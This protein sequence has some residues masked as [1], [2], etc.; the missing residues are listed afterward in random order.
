M[1][2][3][4]HDLRTNLAGGEG[5]GF[6]FRVDPRV[7]IF[8][9]L[10]LLLIN[11]S[12]RGPLLPVILLLS[13]GVLLCFSGIDLH[14]L[15]KS[16]TIPAMVSVLVLVTQ[17]FWV[18]GTHLLFDTTFVGMHIAPTMEGLQRGSRI[19]LQ[20]LSG[21]SLIFLLTR[22]TPAQCLLQGIRWFRCPETLIEIGL[23][24]F[25][26]IFLLFEEGARIR[27]AQKIRLGYTTYR[28][29]V[30]AASNMGGMLFIRAYDRAARTTEA[31]R[32]RGGGAIPVNAPE[33]ERHRLVPE[34]MVALIVMTL[35]FLL[36]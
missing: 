8:T 21:V 15:R 35:F 34:F 33:R 5:K 9:V 26:S 14:S 23:L 13:C 20:V 7:K 6:F 36:R 27:E 19:A 16:L 31:M 12:G 25:R 30:R 24:M 17:L 3:A 22:T 29:A 28:Q 1:R 10:G 32:C 4:M 11:L 18:G 2:R